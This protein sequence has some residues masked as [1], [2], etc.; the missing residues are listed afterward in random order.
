MQSSVLE[1]QG[2][3]VSFSS[4]LSVLEDVHLRLTP[5]IYGLVA[6]SVAQRTREFG[7]RLAL[8]ATRQ[9]I[10]AYVVRQ[11]ATLAAVGVVVGAI[12]AVGLTRT[13]QS[14]ASDVGVLNVPIVLLVGAVLLVVAVL[15]SFV[16]ALRA[17][18][19][20]PVAALRDS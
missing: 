2:V 5:G 13:M 17:V 15:A 7:I 18:R 10:L 16:P 8:G 1:L 12:A 19:L 14:L 20:D 4:L 6:Y 11:G 9:R 3:E